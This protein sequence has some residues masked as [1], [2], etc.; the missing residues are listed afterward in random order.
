M[1][2]L[3]GCLPGAAAPRCPPIRRVA[4]KPCCGSLCHYKGAVAWEGHE[5]ICRAIVLMRQLPE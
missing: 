4:P 3:W 1:A 5:R 2:L